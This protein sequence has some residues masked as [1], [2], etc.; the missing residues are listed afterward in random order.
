[1]GRDQVSKGASVPCRNGIKLVIVAVV[2]Q[3]VTHGKMEK[4]PRDVLGKKLRKDTAS[5]GK[6][7]STIEALASPKKDGTRCLEG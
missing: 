1:M 4:G 5:S 2:I 3:L 6:L 7:V